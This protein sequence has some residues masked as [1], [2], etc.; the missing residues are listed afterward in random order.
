[1][2]YSI[3]ALVAT[4]ADAN[5]VTVNTVTAAMTDSVPAGQSLWPYKKT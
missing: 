5:W 3:A 4:Q 2:S 1:M